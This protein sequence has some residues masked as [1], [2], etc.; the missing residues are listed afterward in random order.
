MADQ[1]ITELGQSVR[2]SHLRVLALLAL[3]RAREAVEEA[4]LVD[5]TDT[6]H[7]HTLAIAH[8][9]AG[10]PGQ[11][12]QAAETWLA[13]E[14]LNEGAV[15]TLLAFLNRRDEANALA[16]ASDHRPG[17]HLG[18]AGAVLECL[19]GAPFD[20]EATPNFKARIEQGELQ[21]PPLAPITLP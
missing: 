4:R 17:G 1:A 19:C 9:A 20:I 6:R 13:Q 2:S 18:L 14:G 10:A 12:R 8:A 15:L 3:G 21:W 16:A 7:G 11:A 5:R